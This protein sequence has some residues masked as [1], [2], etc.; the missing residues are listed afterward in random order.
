M[1]FNPNGYFS[2]TELTSHESLILFLSCFK[3]QFIEFWRILYDLFIGLDNEAD[4]YHAAATVSTLLL[5]LGEETRKINMTT[6][7]TGNDGLDDLILVEKFDTANN[8][9][10]LRQ[11]DICIDDKK[12]SKKSS[13]WSI[14]YEQLLASILSEPLIAQYLDS[15]FEL[16]S[17]VADYKAKHA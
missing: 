9:Q 3:E 14:N 17:K 5:R 6:A 15:K 2:E 16:D 13:E 12:S 4:M 11:R 10:E 1:M 8:G 7:V